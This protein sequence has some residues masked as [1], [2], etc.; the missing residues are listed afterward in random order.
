MTTTK[1]KVKGVDL[2]G[3]ETFTVSS[4][5]GSNPPGKTEQA[6]AVSYASLERF[7][8]D[9]ENARQEFDQKALQELADSMKALNT[10][11]GKPRGVLQPLSV[12]R[13]PDIEGD[14]IINGGARRYRAAKM[15]NIADIPYF[16]D[17]DADDYDKVVDNLV[18]EGL[19]PLETA[20]FIQKRIE[21]RD[22]QV[23]IANHLGKTKSFVSDHLVFFEMADCIRDLY[24]SGKCK[25]MQSLAHL[26]RA[27]KKFPG[28]IQEFC[29]TVSDELTVSQVRMFING[30][31]T[32]MEEKAKP[33][34]EKEA[35]HKNQAG[36]QQE[37]D[38]VDSRESS[39]TIVPGEETGAGQEYPFTDPEIHTQDSETTH[40][41]TPPVTGQTG[42]DET[43]DPSAIEAEADKLIKTDAD[44]EK[45]KKAIIQVKHDGRPARLLYQ[46]RAAYGLAWIKYD[47]DGHEIEVGL[48]DVELVAVI[49]A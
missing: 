7:H 20:L 45:I 28:I 40:V 15:A 14:F 22:K 46:R 2:S 8:E 29:E 10:K 18:R 27:Y 31:K 30:L 44:Q 24:D 5:L 6:G 26:H 21:A 47:D 34:A 38:A 33:T 3:L 16:I 36:E 4:L 25:S 19:S 23:D 1:G 37:P 41:P 9:P 42:T 43:L 13:H 11:T 17:D 35:E 32:P 39:E 48:P 49:E 12:R